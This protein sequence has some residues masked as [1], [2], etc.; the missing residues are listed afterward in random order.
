MTVKTTTSL[1]QKGPRSFIYLQKPF[2][3]DGT[4]PFKNGDK[5]EVTIQGDKLVI[6]KAK[7]K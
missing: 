2:V 1:Y 7:K 3:T 4:F 5:L 6:T